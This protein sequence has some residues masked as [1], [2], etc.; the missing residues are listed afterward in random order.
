MTRFRVP[1]PVGEGEL[2]LATF[3][4]RLE[5]AGV[6]GRILSVD[7]A[8]P[9]PAVT[10]VESCGRIAGLVHKRNGLTRPLEVPGFCLI[11]LLQHIPSSRG[12]YTPRS[13]HGGRIKETWNPEWGSGFQGGRSVEYGE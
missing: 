1:F 5:D 6:P 8:E 13:R 10:A 12:Q 3:V 2:S 4:A 9:S 7:S 11:H